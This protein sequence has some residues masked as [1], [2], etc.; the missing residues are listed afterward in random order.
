M[1]EKYF[2]FFFLFCLGSAIGSFLNVLIDR[3]STCKSIL[4]RSH[5]DHCKEQILW[6]DLFPIFSFVFLKG[7]C[8]YCHKK[9]SFYYPLIEILTGLAFIGTYFI[10]AYP[11]NQILFPD[12]ILKKNNTY[13]FMAYVGIFSSLIVIFFADLKYQIIPD[14]IQ[15][16]LFIF[17]FFF[18]IYSLDSVKA[19]S[20]QLLGQWFFNGLLVMLPILFLFFITR[21]NGMGFGDVKLAFIIGFLLGLKGGLV[22]LYLAFISGAIVGLFLIMLKKKG[23]KSKVAFGPFMVTGLVAVM[24]AGGQIFEVIKRVYGF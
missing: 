19:V 3:L 7:R 13:L 24:L 1:L 5:C 9:L 22:S 23:L 15:L 17:S 16:S 12:V 18:K 2:Y 4:G 11:D 6:H 10:I 20:S 21:G 14:S 8:R